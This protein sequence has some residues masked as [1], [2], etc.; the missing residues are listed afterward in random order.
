MGKV[1]FK[2]RCCDECGS[3]FRPVKRGQRFCSTEH[4]KAFN[5]RAM[6]RGAEVVHLLCALRRERG[7]AKDM[8]LW[9]IICRLE[10]RWRN[11]DEDAGRKGYTDPAIVL[12]ELYDSGRLARG[13]MIA[14][15]PGVS[16]K[17]FPPVY[18]GLR[19]GKA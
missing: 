10:L 1:I 18:R 3:E 14:G 4:R 9:S 19:S 2:V 16:R 13:V 5:N 15:M 11:E 17:D 12:Q 6:L 8:G 7:K